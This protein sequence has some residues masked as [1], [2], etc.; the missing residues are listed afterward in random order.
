MVA[1]VVVVGVA[2]EMAAMI[3]GER[4]RESKANGAGGGR[5]TSIVVSS[6]G[7]GL[8]GNSNNV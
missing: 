2:A 7:L 1:V 3:R 6:P 5:R 4:V 8:D